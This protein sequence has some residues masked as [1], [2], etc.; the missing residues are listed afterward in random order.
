[1]SK[2]KMVC[3]DIDGTLL[4]SKHEI[5]QKTKEVIHEIA[6]EKQIPV[7][8]V[9]ARMPKGIIF[10]HQELN[11]THPVICYS[12][13]LIWDSNKF[14]SSI[15][16]PAYDVRP[17]HRLA[18]KMGVHMSL[19]R[20]DEWYVEEID[21][22][23]DQEARITRNTPNICGF[24]GLLDLWEKE[25]T[26]PNKIL[27]MGDADRIELFQAKIRE[28][29]SGDLNIY[30][31]KT[32]YLEIT[33]GKAMKISAIEFLCIKYGISKSE[34]IAMGDNYNDIN[35]LESV[36][37][38]IAMGNAPDHVKKHAAAVTLTNDEDGVAEA[39]KKYMD[40]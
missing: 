18:E 20:D 26:G 22:W 14:Y 13:A 29:H 9:S 28:Q 2:Y 10:L 30:L 38:G 21:E 16:M 35:M 1:M 24:P 23:A 19:Y 17:I 15:V 4:N 25:N 27:C 11:I 37:L 31:S 32:T 12:G 3:L 34:V 40:L 5:T 8:L 6:N 39:L 7:V 36:G 33:S